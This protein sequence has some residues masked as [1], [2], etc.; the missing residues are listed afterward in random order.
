VHPSPQ[1]LPDLDCRENIECFVDLFY[2]KILQD[3][4]LAPIFLD[5]AAIDLNLHL[6]HIKNYWCKLLL[7]DRTYSR[8]TM[9]IHRQLHGKQA[10]TALDFQRWLD[11]FVT[12]V[13][14]SFSG[15]RAQRA[16]RVAA[17]IAANMAKTLQ[18]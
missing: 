3:E 8:H 13:D 12:V 9:N 10:L 11:T 18:S 15:D 17:T 14:G 4:Q 16:K 6:P 1:S 5:V 2:A 7:G